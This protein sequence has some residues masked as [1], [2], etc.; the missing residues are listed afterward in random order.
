[1]KYFKGSRKNN[2]LKG[3]IILAIYDIIDENKDGGGVKCG[4]LIIAF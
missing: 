3:L 1:M 2:Y 4:D